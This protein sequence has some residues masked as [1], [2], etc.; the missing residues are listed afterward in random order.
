MKDEP[1][2]EVDSHYGSS[3]QGRRGPAAPA[4]AED[5][6]S[7]SADEGQRQTS[8]AAGHVTR[9]V[10]NARGTA[11]Q[12]YGKASD[13]AQDKYDMASRNVTYARRR[14]AAEYNRSRRQVE[15]FVEENPVM[16]GVAG[17]AAGL[18]IGAML[19]GTRRENQVFGRYADEARREGVR[20]A[21]VVA[22]QGKAILEENLQGLRGEHGGDPAKR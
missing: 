6:W 9:V 16:V 5:D 7:A 3:V 11:G 20:Y 15:S 8:R 2:S 14:S 17:L 21:Q 10:E 19:P 22:E 18:L 12:A 4:K 1:M 13:W